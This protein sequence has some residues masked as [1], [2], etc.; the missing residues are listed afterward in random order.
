LHHRHQ[1]AWGAESPAPP[2]LRL[3]ALPLL[4]TL[5]PLRSLLLANRRRRRCHQIHPSRHLV[6]R[7]FLQ[8]SLL[9]L[10]SGCASRWESRKRR[11]CW[12]NKKTTERLLRLIERRA[13]IAQGVLTSSG[14]CGHRKLHITPDIGL[15]TSGFGLSP[16]QTKCPIWPRPELR[17]LRGSVVG[18]LTSRMSR[19]IPGRSVARLPLSCLMAATVVL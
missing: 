2:A 14:S 16:R 18:Y 10:I 15:R 4:L 3:P 19:I 7:G 11:V 8:S 13:I 5:L 1:T 17:G 9:L 6:K 12:G